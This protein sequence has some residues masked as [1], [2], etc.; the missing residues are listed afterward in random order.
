MKFYTMKLAT[1][2]CIWIIPIRHRT[3]RCFLLT[4][5]VLV[6]QYIENKQY[7]IKKNEQEMVFSMLLWFTYNQQNNLFAKSI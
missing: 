3:I 7:L 5:T 6:T 1:Y 2:V 4:L